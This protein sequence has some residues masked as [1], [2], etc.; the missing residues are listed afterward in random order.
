MLISQRVGRSVGQSVSLSISQ[1]VSQSGQSVNLAASRSVNRS[2]SIGQ[3]VSHF[4]IFLSC[5]LPVVLSISL[6]ICLCPVCPYVCLP[7]GRSVRL[8]VGLTVRSYACTDVFNSPLR[9][10]SSHTRVYWMRRGTRAACALDGCCGNSRH[11]QPPPTS[12]SAPPGGSGYR[13]HGHT[14]RPSVP[15]SLHPSTV[16][17]FVPCTLPHVCRHHRPYGPGVLAA[18]AGRSTASLAASN[19]PL[20]ATPSTA[21]SSLG[22]HSRSQITDFYF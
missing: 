8:S 22:V 17:R 4:C 21:T 3:S 12:T 18:R 1:S 10:H 11:P 15:P 7:V 2:Q 9:T 19:L 14:D 13:T 20:D 16:L 5:Y 6:S